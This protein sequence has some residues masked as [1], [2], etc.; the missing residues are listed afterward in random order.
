MVL[1]IGLDVVE[2]ARVGRALEK[3]G[4][5]FED[6]VYTRAESAACAARADRV[7]ALAGRFAA[8]E[9][10][11]KALGT[12]MRASPLQVEGVTANGGPPPLE[13]SG[14]AAEQASR[15]GVRRVLLCVSPEQGVAAA[16]G[17]L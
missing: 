1:G 6:R 13:L 8:K 15:R 9:A 5:R 16:V 17:I 2:T 11:L 14:Q 12:G 10:F 7:A 4:P 3:F